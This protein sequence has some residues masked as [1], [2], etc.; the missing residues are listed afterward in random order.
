MHLAAAIEAGK[1]VFTEKPVAVD[2]PGIRKVLA[3]AEE[4]KKKGLAVVAGTQR[5]HQASYLESMK[6]IHDGAIG[7][8]TVGALLLEPGQPLDRSRASRRGPTWSSR[9]ATGSTSPGSPATT[10]SSSTS[11]TST[12]S[13]GRCGAHPVRAV[14]MGGRQ[15]RTGPEYGHI[16]DH[17]AI[18]YEYPN[19]VHVAEHVPAD[20]RLREQRLRGRRRHQGAAGRRQ[21]PSHRGREQAG[22]TA[23][24][25][26]TSTPTSRS[27]ST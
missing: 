23:A 9:S 11:T 3:A 13:T 18:D 14:G 4:A 17:F 20:R 26:R 12:W 16:F 6:R 5:R 22:G 27:T 24:R 21:R 8:I 7:E 2:G 1:H 19:G 10:S 15:V 25:A